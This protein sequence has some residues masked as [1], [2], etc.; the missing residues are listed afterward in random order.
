MGHAMSFRTR[1][2]AVMDYSTSDRV[3]HHELGVWPQ[4]AQ[5]WKGEGLPSHEYKWNWFYGED[6]LGFDRREFLPVNY[7]MLPPFPR[8]VL[9]ETAQYLVARNSKGI[10]TKALLEGSIGNARMCMDEYISFPVT[11]PED[12]RTLKKRYIAQT[13]ARYPQ[14]WRAQIAMYKNRNM[15]LILGRNCAAGGF[16][17]RA[18]EW[19]GTEN[20]CYAWY[21]QPALMDEMMEFFAD[22]TMATSRP[23]LEAIDFD[24]F[25]LN[26]DFAMKTGPL[27]SPATFKRFIYP[28]MKRLVEFFKAHGVRYVMVD[29][30][31]NCEALIPL[32]LDA[33]VD[34]IWPLER[35]AGMDPLRLRQE[36]GR[37]LRLW[38][39]VDKRIL[40]TERHHISRHL[41]ELLP[42]VE[43]GGFI[44]HVDHTVPPDVPLDNFLYYMETKRRLLAGRKPA[45]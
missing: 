18:R 22:F 14:D 12:F 10:V 44:P 33:G 3:P 9:E 30:D 16:F 21:D 29:S 15:P 19:M 40:A 20:L 26:E 39:G 13:E 2:R 25:N 32:L 4:T 23:A 1:F 45:D 7:D 35:A 17:W 36:Y 38:G 11:N 27:L 28:H 8:E 31:G 41:A 37:D 6:A 42:L 5:R 43:Q 24:Y 34:G